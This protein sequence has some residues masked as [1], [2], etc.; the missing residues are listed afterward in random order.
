MDGTFPEYARYFKA[1]SDPNRLMIADMLVGGELCA[2]VILEQLKITQ[3]T[4]SHHMR[5]LGESGLVNGHKQGKWT[6]Y[7]LNG[8]AVGKCLAF[9]E[10]F[11]GAG[12]NRVS[13]DETQNC[14]GRG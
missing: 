11:A 1:L 6:Y 5:I 4:L 9:L 13:V 3:P 2:C 8:P 12:D 7:S 14:C 10:K